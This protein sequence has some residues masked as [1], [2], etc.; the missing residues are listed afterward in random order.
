MARIVYHDENYQTFYVDV[1]DQQPE[2]TIGR[3]QGN[4]VMI[5]T[6]SLSRYHAKI[7]YQNHRYFLLDLKSSNGSY[8]NNQRVTQQEIHPGDKIRLG[9]VP[10][11]F[12][13]DNRSMNGPSSAPMP[14]RP[15]QINMMPPQQKVIG[16]PPQPKPMNAPKIQFNAG[17]KAPNMA[18]PDMRSVNMRP[19][20]GGGTYRPTMPNQPS[21][22]DDMAKLAANQIASASG[23]DA[24]AAPPSFNPMASGFAPNMPNMNM[25]QNNRPAPQPPVGVPNPPGMNMMPGA[26]NLP[27]P[28]M[29]PN[30]FNPMSSGYVSQNMARANSQPSINAV[31]NGGMNMPDPNAAPGAFNPMASGF[32]PAMSSGDYSGLHPMP[33]APVTSRPSGDFSGLH[34]MPQAPVTSRP[35]G[36]FSGLHPIPQAPVMPNPNAAPQSFDP[37]SSGLVSQ[38]QMN[39]APRPPSSAQRPAMAGVPGQ[40]SGSQMRLDPVPSAP[41]MPDPNAAPQSFD[42]MSSGLVSQMQM[43]NAPR[44]PSGA[45]NPAMAGVPQPSGSQMRLDPVPSAPGMP[46]PNAAPQSFDPMSS[47][48]V[49]QMQMNNAP[50]QP[51]GAQNPAMTGVPNASDAFSNMNPDADALQ[52]SASAPMNFDPM[53][54]G[55]LPQIS[56]MVSSDSMAAIPAVGADMNS[57]LADDVSSADREPAKEEAEDIP[58]ARRAGSAAA[59]ARRPGRANSAFNRTAV[60]SEVNHV[61]SPSAAA[62]AP[63]GN[64]QSNDAAA[65]PA[66]LHGRAGRAPAPRGRIIHNPAKAQE[67]QDKPVSQEVAAVP[68]AEDSAKDDSAKLDVL[69]SDSMAE[70]Y[71]SENHEIADALEPSEQHYTPSG[72]DSLDLA[73][74][75]SGDEIEIDFNPDREIDF[76]P[77]NEENV[78]LKIQTAAP[79]HK[80]TPDIVSDDVKKALEEANKRADSADAELKAVRDELENAKKESEDLIDKINADHDKDLDELR[81]AHDKA[82]EE[83]KAEQEKLLEELKAAHKQELEDLKAEHDKELETLKAEQSEEISKIRAEGDDAADELRKDNDELQSLCDKQQQDIQA[84]KD[85]I[86]SFETTNSKIVEFMPLWRKRFE[87]MIDYANA[88]EKAVLDL[89]L[90]AQDPQAEEYVHSMTDILRFCLDDLH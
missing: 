31:P 11:E 15:G 36:D 72:D 19:I 53:A 58:Q 26:Q 23:A 38:M 39:N 45:Q 6:K 75:P 35:S 33:Q 78:D 37:M 18:V 69:R 67:A 81:A 89:N 48:L 49:S 14:P 22:D 2:V 85:E 42:P 76:D 8:V 64:A 62:G 70:D 16:T 80:E 41:S 25:P 3:N 77:D 57:A 52:D 51:S 54:S 12:I 73:L 47:G 87:E 88:M 17:A 7:I 66:P 43:N 82:I 50:R 59:F 65:I 40:P 63:Q 27:D 74:K 32:A 61:I 90:S 20:S 28:N 4:M 79:E 5:P 55:F 84:L 10:I 83:L 34:P 1:N 30:T 46:D 21:F 68:L 13:D 29:A 44:Q 71:V 24:N 9:D 86:K 56:G 60:P